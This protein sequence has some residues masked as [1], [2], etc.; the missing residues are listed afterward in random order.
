MADRYWVGGTAAWDATAGTKW[1]ATNGGTGGASVP[2]SAD[3]VF[4][5]SLSGTGTVTI[6]GTVSCLS[7]NCTG[8]TGTVTGSTTPIL[9]VNSS[10][11]LSA[12]M[13]WTT[14]GNVLVR[15]QGSTSGRTFTS[16]GKTLY[17]VTFNITG[18]GTVALQDALTVS[19]VITL[20]TGSVTLNNYTVTAL[21]F[22]ANN[23]NF[24]TIAFGT[25]KFVLTGN[26]A[27]IWNVPSSS[28]LTL[29]GTPLVECSYSGSVG[30]RTIAH[31]STGNVGI[32]LSFTAGSDIAAITASSKIIN[33]TFTGFTGSF[34]STVTTT[35]DVVFGAS[36]TSTSALTCPGNLTLGSGMTYASGSITLTATTGKTVTS[37]GVSVGV[38]ITFNGVGGTW[39][40]QDALTT[41]LATTLTA[42][43]IA[44]NG[45]NLTTR[46]FAATGSNTRSIN[47]S[48]GVIY[49]SGSGTN[50]WNLN[51]SNLTCSSNPVV[52]VLASVTSSITSS[53]TGATEANVPDFFIPNMAAA[54]TFSIVASGVVRSLDFTG[55][56]CTWT[57][58]T[59]TMYGSLTLSSTMSIG[60]TGGITFAATFGTNTITTNGKTL[61]G[62]IEINGVGGTYALGSALTLA[63]NR[64][65]AL[66]NGSFNANNFSVT[67]TAF[68][69]NNSNVRSLTLG[70]STVTVTASN[71]SVAWDLPTST[72]MTLS[73]SASTII[74]ANAGS[75]GFTGPINF[76]G[77]GLTYG[78]VTMAG[79]ATAS[80][81]LVVTGANTFATLNHTKTVAFTVTLP[82]STTT[83]VTTWGI[84]GTAGNLITLNSSTA[85]TQATLDKAG[86]GTVSASYLSIQDSNATPGSTWT[87]SNST[88]A[89]NNTGW[90]F[91]IP[92]IVNVTSVTGTGGVGSVTT[93]TGTGVSVNV[94]GVQGLT[95]VGTVDVTTGG[96][97]SVNL[98]G[99]QATGVIGDVTVV[100]VASISVN[101]TGVQ[102]TGNTGTVNVAAKSN[103][104][105][106]GVSASGAIGSVF[107]VAISN[108]SINA[109]GVS[110]TGDIG[111]V[112]IS[113][114]IQ[115]LVTS[116]SAVGDI[117]NVSVAAS[118]NV[119]VTDVE[120][121]GA[122]GNVAF[123][124][125]ANILVTGVQAS[126]EIGDVVVSIPKTIT[127]TGVEAT[128][129]L[130]VVS[131]NTTN[132]ISVSG[133][134]ATGYVGTVLV[135]GL[136]PDNQDP[137]WQI[138]DDSQAGI[139]TVINDAQ[140]PNWT[141]IAA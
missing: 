69:S 141:D 87:A 116:V 36:M 1:S 24:R 62:S 15:L 52:Y 59:L 106:T 2:T 102:A 54:N 133:V 6:T 19:D 9:Q 29:T 4:F 83:T 111:D 122:V 38:N 53:A 42:G 66:T 71:P 37:N 138:I 70:T 32:N 118:A 64:V 125:T 48:S 34:G 101:V 91:P 40:L 33:L 43:T 94:T 68:Q 86:G 74:L 41:T 22:A 25:G 85:A 90:S 80:Q 49:L 130:G 63:A 112:L 124:S 26:S 107:V 16:A 115:V 104:L 84:N 44:L 140:T 95:N 35:G 7:F 79:G 105:V 39:T 51:Y 58:N 92:L 126:G 11:T 119:A 120:A 57:V 27:T 96:A 46:N 30:T 131:L 135:W 123:T 10:F 113:L 110:S 8:F 72:N 139:W 128:T 21:A 56:S 47:S 55:A 103:T 45:F 129:A 114:P 60:G 76:Y 17:Q 100:A 108:V 73:A 98:T 65:V 18:F 28:S 109:T 81:T 67:A 31:S 75:G 82:A 23:T 5:T 136:I 12:G 132:R 88:D 3:N 78:T 14:A 20:T 50:V 13:T 89:G 127:V 61:P 134:Q 117:G 137:N 99:V 77:G 93:L 121:T 97:I